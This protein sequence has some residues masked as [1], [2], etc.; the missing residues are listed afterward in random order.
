[1][2]KILFSSACLLISIGSALSQIKPV[3]PS[4]AARFPL[5]DVKLLDSPFLKAEQTDLNYILS[6]DPDRLLAPFLRE[7][8]ITPKASSY[9]NWENTG[10][11]GHVGGHYLTA[12]ALMCASTGNPKVQE[13]LNYM[14]SELKRCQ[15][16]NGN[17]YIGGT[18]GGLEMW[19]QVAQGKIEVSNFS[20]NNKWVPWY[21]I[22]KLYAGLRDAYWYANNQDAKEMLIKLSDWAVKL[23]ANL[24]EAQIQKM[25]TAEHGGM[26]E[27]FADVASI[28]GDKKYLDLARKFSHQII[29]TPL[30]TDQDKLNGLHANTQIPKVIGF[31]RIAELDGDKSYEEAARFFW[32]TVVTHRSVAIGGNS[33][34]EHFHPASDFTSM[35]TDVEGPET[36][37]TYN[38]LKLTESLYQTSAEVKYIDYYEKGLY[39]HIL[40]S[41]HPDRGGFVYFTPMRPRHYRVYSQPQSSFWCC[42]GSGLENHA[43]YGE[44]IYAHSTNELFVNLFIPSSVSWK[45]KNLTLT[46]QTRFPDSEDVTLLIEAKKPTT[47]E[48]K[49]RYP[50]WVSAGA[51]TVSINGKAEKI[52]A[53][54]GTYISLNRKWKTG[55]KIELHIPMAN[56]LEQIAD[57]TNY[58]AVFHG[59][60]LLAAKTDTTDLTGLFADDSRMG[61]VAKGKLYP[62]S[63]SPLLVGEEKNLLASLTP[64]TGKSLTFTASDVIYPKKYQQIELIPFF[65]LHDARYVV[66]WPQTTQ[67]QIAQTQEMLAKKEYTNLKDEQRTVDKVFPGEQQPESD[68]FFTGENTQTGIHKNRHWRDARGWFSYVLNNK[69]K[70]ATLLQVTYYGLDK[71]RTF[72]IFLNDVKVTRV[73]LDGS[74][75]DQFFTAE[76]SIPAQVTQKSKDDKII[77]KF[78]AAT[79]SVA[80]GVYDVRLLKNY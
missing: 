42:V 58:Y 36:C 32:E 28:T 61:H 38:M 55:D 7:A 48:V 27:I 18:P 31:K 57:H 33:V 47:L 14:I 13:R 59:P 70:K 2:K 29:L 66:Y 23:V 63:E 62:L 45:E 9:T 5:Q 10:L 73:T 20:L 4:K 8:G 11:D 17:G 25:L 72:D 65:R 76:Y 74:R 15:D 3:E 12:L 53:T 41:Q 50:S 35:I 16:K 46:Q 54:P 80:G 69:E 6:L 60:I 67:A 44:M 64:V 21:N 24:D 39:N 1:M 79:G 51:L 56:R 30:A 37:N 22:H 75:G 19:K 34:R 78:V 71:D 77:V 68:H 49:V 43:K 52:T 26:N 40:S